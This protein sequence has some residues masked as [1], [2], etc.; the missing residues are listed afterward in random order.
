M[1]CQ[2]C[3]QGDSGARAPRLT[4]PRL[5]LRT[6]P[7]GAGGNGRPTDGQCSGCGGPLD[8]GALTERVSQK[9]SQLAQFGLADREEPLLEARKRRKE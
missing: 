3:T 8:T 4:Q 9:R 1:L 2:H 6:R 5:Q 7:N